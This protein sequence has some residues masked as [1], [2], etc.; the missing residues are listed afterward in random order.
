MGMKI[1]GPGRSRINVLAITL[2]WGVN[3][4]SAVSLYS[5]RDPLH[6]ICDPRDCKI[7]KDRVVERL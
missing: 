5:V 6:F 3:L 4:P 2:Q 7:P 1:I